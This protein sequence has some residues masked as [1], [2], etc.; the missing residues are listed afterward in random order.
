MS[1]SA[2][3]CAATKAPSTVSRAAGPEHVNEVRLIGE[4]TGPPEGRT[5]PDGGQV[6]AFRLT[7][8][9]LA[10]PVSGRAPLGSAPDARRHNDSVDCVARRPALQSRLA[11]CAAGDV[12]KLEGALRH[13]YWRG[14]GGLSSRY[15]VEVEAVS[16]V[17]RRR[18]VSRAPSDPA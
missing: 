3:T 4:V 9:S 18:T 10:P 17:K 14:A 13:R 12:I 16:V 5:L 15:E 7:V 1:R 8:R 2:D 6:L 11:R